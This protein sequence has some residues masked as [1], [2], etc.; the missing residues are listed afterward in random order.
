MYYSWI[1]SY[2]IID[3]IL[4]SKIKADMLSFILLK[5]NLFYG[6]VKPNMLSFI[7]LKFN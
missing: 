3:D 7:L 5:F 1:C 4:S 6:M 2:G